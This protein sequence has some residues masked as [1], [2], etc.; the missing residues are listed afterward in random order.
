MI[1]VSVS[2]ENKL[3]I[4]IAVLIVVQTRTFEC[5]TNIC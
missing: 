1:K 5:F 4:I 2:T 3:S